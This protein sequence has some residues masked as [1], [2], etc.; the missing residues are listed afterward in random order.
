MPSARPRANSP[1]WQCEC[2]YP[3]HTQFPSM[4][5]RPIS[6]TR[7]L[8]GHVSFCAVGVACENVNRRIGVFVW[9]AGRSVI[10]QA[11]SLTLGSSRRNAS[12]TTL[13][14][15]KIR[16]LRRLAESEVAEQRRRGEFN[17]VP[18]F[19]VFIAQTPAPTGDR[20]QLLFSQILIWKCLAALFS[21]DFAP[22]CRSNQLN[23]PVA[24]GGSRS[25]RTPAGAGG[26]LPP[27]LA[28]TGGLQPGRQPVSQPASR[29]SKNASTNW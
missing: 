19:R 20:H 21:V 23:L 6:A 26:D 2:P 24:F 13:Q 10:G 14:Q 29:A 12:S 1:G 4:S 22:E 3:Y 7:R 11:T 8:M 5:S 17:S 25:R 15:E 9:R 27:N 28:K 16:L 18:H